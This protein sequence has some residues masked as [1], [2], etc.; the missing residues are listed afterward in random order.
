MVRPDSFE[1]ARRRGPSW[2]KRG[3][4]SVCMLLD[5]KLSPLERRL[6]RV[7][8]ALGAM[9]LLALGIAVLAIIAAFATGGENGA[10]GGRYDYRASPDPVLPFARRSEPSGEKGQARRCQIVTPNEAVRPIN[11]SR[12]GIRRAGLSIEPN[13]HYRTP[14]SNPTPS[15]SCISPNIL[16]RLAS[17]RKTS[18][19]NGISRQTS[20]L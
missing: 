14:V 13:P 6:A 15:A 19:N 1:A 4:H 16:C 20:A 5:E 2:R 3:C 9:G 18:I 11:F 8:T 12:R 7:Q 17:A 10:D